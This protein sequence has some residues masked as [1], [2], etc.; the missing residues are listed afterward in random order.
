MRLIPRPNIFI[1]AGVF[2]LFPE[3]MS[4]SRGTRQPTVTRRQPQCAAEPG[5]R[6]LVV[7]GGHKDVLDGS[8][9]AYD[10]SIP[11]SAE[12]RASQ[13]ARCASDRQDFQQPSVRRLKMNTNFESNLGL[14]SPC[15][16]AMGQ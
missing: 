15:I 1:R 8:R 16:R 12:Q 3:I 13:D 4:W 9:R 6:S 5:G 14:Y 11:P 10:I 2:L 7:C